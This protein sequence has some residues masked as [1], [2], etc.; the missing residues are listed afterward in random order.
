MSM[1][2]FMSYP[3]GAYAAHWLKVVGAASEQPIFAHVNWFQRD[4]D[5]GHFLWPG[6]RDNLRALLWLVR[7]KDGEVTGRRTPAGIVPTAEELDLTGMDVPARDLD[8]LLGIDT[9]RWRQEM[10]HREEHLAQFPDLPEE[11]WAAHRRVAAAF[12]AEV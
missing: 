11:I 1:R 8:R 9:A 6:Y 7:L 5:D 12:D 2:P 10:G 3:E 4:P